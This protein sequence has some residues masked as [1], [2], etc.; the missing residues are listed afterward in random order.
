M[1]AQVSEISTSVSGAVEEQA[2]ATREVSS[3]IQ[4]VQEAAGET[5]RSSNTLLAVA[6]TMS[7]Q[8]DE[9]GARVDGFLD[10]VRTM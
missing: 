7:E 6:R 2:A 5:G 8:A 3:N 10:K 9:L 1:I 4:G